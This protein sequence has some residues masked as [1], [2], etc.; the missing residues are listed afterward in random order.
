VCGVVDRGD[1]RAEEESKSNT[2]QRM[3]KVSSATVM[4]LQENERQHRV[5]DASGM[6]RPPMRTGAMAAG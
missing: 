2:G 1:D 3:A 6:G 5:P 4:K